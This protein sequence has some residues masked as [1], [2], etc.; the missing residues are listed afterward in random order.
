MDRVIPHSTDGT[1]HSAFVYMYMYGPHNTVLLDV[2]GSQAV[3]TVLH[4][5]AQYDT[6]MH[7]RITIQGST[8][9]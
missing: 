7:E 9:R 8:V 6:T 3:W 4:R 5:T 2:R 1:M